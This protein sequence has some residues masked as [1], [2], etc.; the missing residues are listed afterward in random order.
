MIGVFW[1]LGWIGVVAVMALE[2]GEKTIWRVLE[3]RNERGRFSKSLLGGEVR[4]LLDDRNGQY[5]VLVPKK[6]TVDIRSASADPLYHTLRGVIE[7]WEVGSEYETLQK[8]PDLPED[9]AQVVVVTKD[10]KLSD[11]R[12]QVAIDTRQS[13]IK[14]SNGLIYYIDNVLQAPDKKIPHRLKDAGPWEELLGVMLPWAKK[15]GLTVFMPAKAAYDKAKRRGATDKHLAKRHVVVG[16]PIYA[17]DL[18]PGFEVAARDHTLLRVTQEGGGGKILINGV[19]LKET[20]IL[21]SFGVVHLLEGGLDPLEG[22]PKF[23]EAKAEKFYLEQLALRKNRQEAKRLQKQLKLEKEQEL[24]REKAREDVDLHHPIPIPIMNNQVA[25]N[26]GGEGS[27]GDW[28]IWWSL[29]LFPLIM[30]L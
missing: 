22:D 17:G 8:S 26:S 29:L 30:G 21:T 19:A 14:C 15:R 28:K 5:T 18:V 27:E 3:E 9:M 11:G 12:T 16:D 7:E 25:Q 10:G 24:L 4:R 13:P 6:G 20:N 1:W 2:T 23:D